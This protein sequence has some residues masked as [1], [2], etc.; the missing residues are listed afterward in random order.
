MC[1]FVLYLVV[2]V[3]PMYFGA[4]FNLFAGYCKVRSLEYVNLE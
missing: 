1:N 3:Y 2:I 4:I